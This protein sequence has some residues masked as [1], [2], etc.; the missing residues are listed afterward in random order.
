MENLIAHPL[1]IKI[2]VSSAARIYFILYMLCI[3]V[4]RPGKDQN[5]F[6]RISARFILILRVIGWA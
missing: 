4:A 6:C 2:R 5:G 1:I 3:D